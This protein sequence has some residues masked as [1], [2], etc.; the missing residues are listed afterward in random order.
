MELDKRVKSPIQSGQ[1]VLICLHNF[2]PFFFSKNHLNFLLKLFQLK[3]TRLYNDTGRKL[4]E[5][6]IQV[7]AL[8]DKRLKTRSGGRKFDIG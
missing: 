5:T 7:Q 4:D 6:F 1:P 2:F 8:I 3:T